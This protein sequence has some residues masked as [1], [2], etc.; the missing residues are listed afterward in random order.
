L[1][2]E[3]RVDVGNDQRVDRGRE[4]LHVSRVRLEGVRQRK[5]ELGEKAKR[6]LAHDHDQLRLD[7]MQLAR[8]KRARLLD[9]LA[10]ELEAVRAVDRHRVDLQALERLQHCLPG[11]SVEGDALLRLRGLRPVLEQEDV[12]EWMSR[13]D[14]GE[15]LARGGGD[16]VPELV[17]PGDRPLKVALVDL[18]GRHGH[19]S[20]PSSSLSNPFL[21]LR[22]PLERLQVMKA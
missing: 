6:V 5:G 21:C 7:D 11:A 14:D 12:P 18:V 3:G 19:G 4:P 22:R 15:A 2:V 9:L 17:A 10:G 13:T 1:L 20:V 8:E 16:F